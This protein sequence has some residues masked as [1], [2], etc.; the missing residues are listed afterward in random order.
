MIIQKAFHWHSQA[1]RGVGLRCI[2]FWKDLMPERNTPQK[3]LKSWKQIAGYLERSEEQS[4]VGKR[5]TAFLFI[6]SASEA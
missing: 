2:I 4:A 6:V 5:L 3:T 1:A